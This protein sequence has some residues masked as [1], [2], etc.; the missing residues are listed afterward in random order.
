MSPIDLYL[1]K[2]SDKKLRNVCEG[3]THDNEAKKDDYNEEISGKKI[4]YM[5]QRQQPL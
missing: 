4:N 5:K 2:E 3:Y 1:V